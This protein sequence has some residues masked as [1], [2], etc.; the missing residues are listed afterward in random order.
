MGPGR[1]DRVEPIDWDELRETQR[2]GEQE[3]NK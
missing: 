1:P 3:A 2:R